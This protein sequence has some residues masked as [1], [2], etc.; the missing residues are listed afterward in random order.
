MWLIGMMGSGKT[1]LG[2][3][4]ATEVGVPFFDTDH[5]VAAMAGMTI[6]EIWDQH[7]EKGFRRLEKRAVVA[8]PTSQCVA[9]A[10]GGAVLDDESR[11]KIAAAPP[12]VWL[13]CGPEQLGGRVEVIGR[14]LLTAGNALPVLERLARER[15]PIYRSLATHQIDTEHTSLDEALSELIEIWNG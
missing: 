5:I 10:G 8:V 9:A 2:S 14:P 4:L 11:A 13:R 7:G 15:E 1:T 6:A 3:A 12:V